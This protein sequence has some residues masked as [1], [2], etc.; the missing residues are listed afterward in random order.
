MTKDE[1]AF[2]A[3]V[4]LGWFSITQSGDIWR[5]VEFQGGTTSPTMRWVNPRRAET[6]SAGMASY[7]RIM[8]WT[9]DGRRKVSAHRVVWIYTNRAVIPPGMEINHIDGNKQ[10]LMPENLELVTRKQN[11][12]HSFRSL[13]RKKKAQHGTQN[14]GALLTDDQVI[15]IR[16]LW[17]ARAMTQRA[18]GQRFG[19]KQTTV[20]NIVSRQTWTH[21]P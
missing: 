11:V 1:Q 3:Q 18:I 2:L 14:A 21:L 7:L 15:E 8:F 5:H 12:E 20:Y 17:A 19:V 6:S 10:N 13:P 16:A 9:P 4:A